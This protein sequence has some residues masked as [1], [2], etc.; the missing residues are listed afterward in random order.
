LKN[1]ILQPCPT[2]AYLAD[3]LH[4]TANSELS[5][6]STSTI[7]CVIVRWSSAARAFPSSLTGHF[8]PLQ[9]V[10]LRVRGRWYSLTQHAI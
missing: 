7:S 3:E 8:Q 4:L 2:P 9:L 5:Q 1:P 6:S 10:G